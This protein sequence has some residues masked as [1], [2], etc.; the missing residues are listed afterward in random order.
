MN[1][2]IVYGNPI[3]YYI[4]GEEVS[5]AAFH[6]L[7]PSRLGP[8]LR[9]QCPPS[10]R[11]D[12]EFLM[13]SENGRQ[14]QGQEATG[15]AYKKVAE[16]AGVS[17]TGK[18]YLSQLARYPGDPEAWVS[19]RGDVQRICEKRGWGCNGLVDVKAADVG[20]RPDPEDLSDDIVAEKMEAAIGE[21]D[22]R[23]V[24]LPS[25]EE[26]VRSQHRPHWVKN[27]KSP[28]KAKRVKRG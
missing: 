21:A 1:A 12:R 27:K 28:R 9:D 5:E 19:G 23:D 15:E 20:P 7:A 13:G 14:F 6:F 10:S 3:R 2:R 22:V 8:M 26:K 16:S 25:L 11:T 24:D 18:K 17:V 4:E